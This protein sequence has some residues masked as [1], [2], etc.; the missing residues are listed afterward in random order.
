MDILEIELLT[1]NIE[2]TSNFYSELLG[3]EKLH[4][5]KKTISF[6]TGQSVLTFKQSN[7][8]KP[9]YHFAFNIPN[10]K[11]DEAILW[12]SPKAK[13][14]PTEN[15]EVIAD[16]TNINAKSIYFYDNNGNILEFIARFNLSNS[17]EEPFTISSIQSISEIGIVSDAPIKLSEKLKQEND[18]SFCTNCFR[19]EKFIAL[20]NDNGL[21]IIVLTNRHW[22][23]TEMPAEKHFTKIKFRSNNQTAEITVNE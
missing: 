20:G 18:L 17:S 3:F 9:K 13:L 22:Y 12:T 5:D 8:L 11:L 14:L 7:N 4:A 15:G 6:K 21:F 1:D 10:N 19:S 2:E 23:P 16:F